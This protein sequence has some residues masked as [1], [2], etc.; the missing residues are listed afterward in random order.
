MSPTDPQVK[1]NDPEGQFM[2]FSRSLALSLVAVALIAPAGAAA[3][4]TSSEPDAV[5]EVRAR[6]NNIKTADGT[7]V[8]RIKLT[9][10]A[11]LKGSVLEHN[12]GII[13]ASTGRPGQGRGVSTPAFDGSSDAPRAAIRITNP[14]DVDRLN[15]GVRGFSYGV[16]FMLDAHSSEVGS[17]DEGDNLLQR[18]LFEDEDQFKLQVDGRQPSCRIEGSVGSGTDALLVGSTVV[19]DSTHWY[20]A[21]CTRKGRTLTIAVT[22]FDP[23]GTKEVTKT[24][25]TSA[26]VIDVRMSSAVVPLSVGGAVSADGGI[27]VHNDAFNGLIDNVSLDLR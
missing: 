23:D 24:H 4:A 7:R 1:P 5:P 16:D 15:P 25:A 3:A 18:G 14:T 9:G 22:R 8:R 12:G 10:S 19:V 6:F 17:T 11:Q 27:Y 20:R 2:S 13:R 26:A 21:Q